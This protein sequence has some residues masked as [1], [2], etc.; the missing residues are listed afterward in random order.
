[1]ICSKV[2]FLERF[3]DW[4]IIKIDKLYVLEINELISFFVSNTIES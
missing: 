2:E 3:A 4:P 1:M